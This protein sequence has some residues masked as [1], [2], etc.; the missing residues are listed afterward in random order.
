MTK[1]F[2]CAAVLAGLAF[3]AATGSPALAADHQVKMLNRGA[4]GMMV[5]EPAFLAIQPGDTVTFL[6]ADAGHNAEA[7]P[8]MLPEGVEPFAGTM[9]KEI[10]VT[11]AAEGLYGY[12]CKP[13]YAMGMVGL[14]Q[15]GDE[16]PNAAAAAK[17]KHPGKAGK[18][19]AGLFGEAGNAVATLPK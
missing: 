6:V 11:F 18:V 14:I 12:K 17:V 13:H 2:A 10:T 7:I 19:M 4:A 8:G 16:A 5:F 3:G 9:N 15:V 1:T